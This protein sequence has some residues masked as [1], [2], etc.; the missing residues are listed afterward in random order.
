MTVDVPGYITAA[1]WAAV[2]VV[3]YAY[4]GYPVVLMVLGVFRTSRPASSGAGGLPK[5]S[6]L[7]SAYNEAAVI[8]DKL[9]NSLDLDYPEELLEIVVVSDASCDG[10]DDIVRKFEDRGIVLMRCEG[11]IGKTACLNRAVPRA[12]GDIIVFSDANSRYDRRAVRCL[13]ERFSDRKIGFVTGRTEYLSP[14]GDGGL[15]P[16]GLYTRVEGLTKALEGRIGS[17]VG[18]DGAIF[19]IRKFLYRPLDASD[20]NDLVVPARIVQQGYRG[21]L[22]PDAFCLEPA[23]PDVSGEFARHVRITTRSLRAIFRHSS[24]LNPFRYPLFSFELASHKLVRFIVPFALFTAFFLNVLIAAAGGGPVYGATLL[25]Q[26][27]FYI[28][29]LAGSLDIPLSFLT[30]P[31]RAAHTFCAVN[32]AI[33]IGWIKF[34][35]G[36]KFTTWA[37]QR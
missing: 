28:L 22:A 3:L 8:E 4:A 25:M 36:E 5:V 6:L 12:A 13:V 20:I 7:I 24:L 17:C 34:L 23:A 26:V 32:L 19:A 15:S 27:C 14:A 35:K 31:S 18:A 30:R 2:L 1:F 9:V 10:T 11:H 21:V 16:A 33:L 29:W 37:T